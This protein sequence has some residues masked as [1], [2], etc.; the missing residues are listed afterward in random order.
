MLLPP[1][2]QRALLLAAPLALAA[3]GGGSGSAETSGPPAP[4]G[5]T[6]GYGV[7]AYHFS[8]NASANAS[9]YELFEDPDGAAGPMPEVQVGGALGGTSYTHSLAPQMLHER[10]NASYRLRA[11]D[12]GSCGALTAAWVPDLTK[13]IGYFKASNSGDHDGYGASVALSTDG[14]TLAV[15][16]P[17]ESSGAAG[18]NGDQADNSVEGAGA[19]YVFARSGSGWSQQAYVKA[20]NPR[21]V[22]VKAGYPSSLGWALFGASLSLSA[23]GST[24]AVGAPGEASN[25]RGTDGDQN[26]LEAPGAGAVYVFQRSGGAWSQQAYVKASNTAPAA[27]YRTD[28]AAGYYVLNAAEFGKSISLSADGKVL[29]VGAP[30]EQGNATG[31]NGNQGDTST[32]DAGAVYMFAFGTSWSQQAYLKASTIAQGHF[33]TSVSLAGNARTL[34]VGSWNDVHVF[35][36]ESGTWGQQ[37]HLAGSTLAP[38]ADAATRLAFFGTTTALAADGSTLAIGALYE[39]T[40][41]GEYGVMATAY[42]FG[43]ANGAWTQQTRL[44]IDRQTG[45]WVSAALALSADGNTLALGT[46]ADSSSATG[47]N[48]TPAGGATASGATRIF[49]RSGATWR[50][51]AYLKAS[52]TDKD[53]R[54]GD[55]MALSGDGHTLAV[56]AAGEDSKATG[57]QGDQSDNSSAAGVPGLYEPYASYGAVYLY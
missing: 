53:D 16:A 33:G 44:Q 4:A 40:R 26:N 18:L 28:I 5:L 57:L 36:G 14:S 12:A 11:C 52:N 50:Q 42:V 23:D 8:W 17:G 39:P 34:A 30:G 56:G 22:P 6:V 43:R 49:Q 13:A 41:P 3:C 51:R 32:D 20:S 21:A 9:R 25:A 35:S 31:T 7:K 37:A 46:G 15:G 19:V 54:F 38:L 48:S 27:T 45:A 24:L 29:A 2:R 55:S 10:V 1:R 47:I